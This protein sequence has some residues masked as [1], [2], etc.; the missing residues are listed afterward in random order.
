MI[1]T[2]VDITCKYCLNFVRLDNLHMTSGVT[3]LM[4]VSGICK[5]CGCK[6]SLGIT[7]TA[8]VIPS[9]GEE[10]FETVVV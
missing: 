5:R 3:P 6:Y 9:E 8:S 1:G 2:M 7:K 4:G 10:I